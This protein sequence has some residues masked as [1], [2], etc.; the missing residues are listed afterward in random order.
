LIR[1]RD[2]CEAARQQNKAALSPWRT[3]RIFRDYNAIL[4]QALTRNPR[5]DRQANRRGRVKQSVAFNRVDRMREH[6]EAVL[7]FVT[8][9]RVPFTNNL[10]ERAIRTPKVKQKS[11]VAFVPWPAQRPSAPSVPTPISCTNRVIICS[12][13]CAKLS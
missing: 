7:R 9:L 12:R 10:A 4:D 2:H 11:P 1:A 13:C 5:A 8:E 6:G 3:R